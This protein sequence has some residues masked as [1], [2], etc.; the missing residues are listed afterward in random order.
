[1]ARWRFSSRFSA[2]GAPC[3]SSIVRPRRTRSVKAKVLISLLLVLL[4]TNL[5][6]YA[7]TRYKTTKGVLTRAGERMDE[8]L[9]KEGLYEQVYS[10]EHPRFISITQ[11][12]SLAGG[13]YYWWND[14]LTYWGAAGLLIIIGVL[15]PF[16][17]RRRT[18]A[19]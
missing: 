13:M 17:R 18:H 4:G 8:A 3:L 10:A 1:M 7:T 5:F 16:V 19:S 2:C 12:I 6:T 9:K 14:A 15:V 11:A